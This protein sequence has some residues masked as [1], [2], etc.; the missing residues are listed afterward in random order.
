MGPLKNLKERNGGFIFGISPRYRIYKNISAFADLTI[1]SNVSQHLNWDG[2]QLSDSKTSLTGSMFRTSF[3]ISLALGKGNIHGDWAIIKDKNERVIDSLNNRIG[4]IEEMLSD[5][6]KDGVPDYL[7]AEQ[8][9]IAGVAVDSKGRMI[10]KN[11]NGISDELEKYVDNSISTNNSNNNNAINAASENAILRLIN[12][13]YIAVY[14]D[15]EQSQPNSASNNNIGFILNYLK[16][17][18]DKSVDIIGY[19]DEVGRDDYN[20]KLAAQRAQNVKSILVKAGISDSRIS[21]TSNGED[22][23]VDKKSKSA[24]SLVRKTIFKIK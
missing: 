5:T 8:N 2:Q 22:K 23:S 17:N 10:D 4:E 3:G 18:P 1:N 12:E 16:N 7:D 13:G 20:N 24:R 14:F 9:S 6:D 15:S 11:N 21:V 19:A